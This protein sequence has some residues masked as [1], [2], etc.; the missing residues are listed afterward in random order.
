MM[1]RKYAGPIPVLT[2]LK[3]LLEM[4]QKRYSGNYFL[5]DHT[6]VESLGDGLSCG[7]Y[8]PFLSCAG[9]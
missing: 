8:L 2:R 9:S 4:P 1:S 6:N 5:D 7:F 3:L